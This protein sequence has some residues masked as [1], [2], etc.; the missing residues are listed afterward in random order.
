MKKME[1]YYIGL[2]IGTSSVGWAVTDENYKIPKFNGKKMWGVRLFEEAKTAKERR[3]QRGARRR[4]NRRKERINLLQ[5][6]FAVEISKIDKKFFLRLKNSDLYREDK[7]KKLMSKYSL[8]NDKKFNDKDYYKKYPT[9]HHLIMDLINDNSKKD[10]RLVYL[11]CHYLL[12]NRGHFIFEGQK[13]DMNSS[14]R[15]SIIH[16]KNHLEEFYDEDVEFDNEELIK[17]LT[18]KG[19]N[20]TQKKK[21]LETILGKSKLLKGIGTIIVGGKQSLKTMFKNIEFEDSVINAIDFTTTDFED[22]YS[23]Y[24]EVLGESIG[25]INILKEIYDS[26]VL[27]ILLKDADNSIDGKKYISSAFIKKYNKHAKDLKKLKY[28]V[29][30]YLKHEYNNIFRKEEGFNNYVA[31]TKTNITQSKHIK[32]NK[33]IKSDEF[34]KFIKE[35]LGEIEKKN[36]DITIDSEDLE[37]IKNI[38]KEIDLKIFMPKLKSSDNAVIPYQLKLIELQK[39]L[40]NQSNYYEF[41]NEED[42]YG[43]VKEKIESIMKFR[44]P[45]YVGPLNLE[46]E[47]AWVKRYNKKVTPWNFN[48]VIDLDL[49]RQEFIDRLIGRCTYLKNEKVLPKSSL[50]YSEFMVLDELNNLKINGVPIMEEMK[51]KIF[52]KLFKTRKKV[53]VKAVENLIKKDFNII[54]DILISGTDGDFKQGLNSY[55]DF[56][57]I[58]GEKIDND[59]YRNKIEEIIELLVLYSDDKNYLKKKLKLNYKNY[60]TEDEI[61]KIYL[62]KYKDWGRF[63]R[64]FLVGINGVNKNTGEI[65][66]IMYFMREYNYNH[67]ELM[68]QNFTFTEEIQKL[69]PIDEKKISYEMIDELYL[70]SPVKRMLWQSLKIVDEIKKILGKDS[71]KIFIEMARGK[72]RIKKEKKSRKDS[73]LGFYKDGKKSFINELGE[74]RYNELVSE[75]KNEEDSK[76]R[77][78]NLY[79]YYTQLG[80]CMYSGEVIEL[81]ELSNKNIYDQD[82]IYPKS[83]IYDDSIENRVLVKKDLNSKK[84]NEYPISDSIL[85]PNIRSFWKILYNKKLIGQKKYT[86]L[87]RKTPFS[88][89]EYVQF[90]ERQIV[91]TRQATKET[92]NLLKFICKDSDIVYSKAENVSKFRQE[93]DIVKC[94]TI[95]DLHH[96]HDA[97][98]N[99]VVGNVY[100]T[101]FTK[102]P[103]NFINA[104]YKNINYNLENMFK[105]DVKRGNYIAW[106]AENKDR[107][108]KNATIRR[109]KKEIAGTNFRV[110]Q[111]SY[112]GKG[113]LFKQNILRKGK[114]QISQKNNSPKED[115]SKYGEYNKASSAYFCLVEFDGKS[116]RKKTIETIPVYVYNQV[117]QGKDN[118]LDKYLKD[119]LR[120]KNYKILLDKIKINSLVKLDGFYYNIRG[121]TGDDISVIGAVQLI[122]SNKEQ[123]LIKKIDKFLSRKK[124]NKNLKIS[125]LDNIKED[126]LI[127]LY[128]KLLNKLNEGIYSY[129]RN[130]QA[131]NIKNTYDK[132]LCLSIEDKLIVLSQILLLF[133]RNNDGCDLREIGL[134]KKA[135]VIHINKKLNVKEFKLIN[136]SV[137]GLFENEVDLLKL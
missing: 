133:K 48:E 132:F 122:L 15:K 20:K 17:S 11:A 54:D 3:I 14:F 18:D 32:A 10:I 88:N 59:K 9:I 136:Q 60:F 64:R 61:N 26:S 19:L 135:G 2:D 41:L 85:S 65:G 8:F 70:S 114:G 77:W 116:G 51:K 38:N 119:N 86:R 50:L 111:M 125:K 56:K 13:F 96:M 131:I 42:K 22:K 63:S 127:D 90:I 6:F 44:I 83:K 45:Y 97:Y 34:Y 58:V 120:A 4:L 84:G 23:D 137:T 121:K 49:S 69:N 95:N 16:L 123:K 68:S 30:K 67:M 93:F 31:Y 126:E 35:K 118:L 103:I 107:N 21:K 98:L 33:F 53:T 112:I 72:E 62:L 39:I 105:Y 129:K 36:S 28:L 71:K 73:L 76:F 81:S 134:S 106:I 47:F 43:T 79:L 89:D 94:R 99:I 52:N 55:I 87:T 102:S 101:K 75:I 128:N 74:E 12:K 46:S 40:E 82:H 25:L 91:E 1:D 66:N 78:D 109:V 130:N 92:A 37:L 7:D 110:T 104:D 57:N 80:R 117:K 100:N 113:E 27:E 24:E 5:N 115:I 108:I 124:D 29:K